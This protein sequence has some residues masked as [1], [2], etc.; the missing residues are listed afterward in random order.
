[1]LS[2]LGENTKTLAMQVLPE[3]GRLKFWLIRRNI[4]SYPWS[5]IV[6]F[7]RN[8]LCSLLSEL[9]NYIFSSEKEFWRWWNHPRRFAEDDVCPSVRQ[10]L[11]SFSCP[12]KE[13][14]LLIS[15][16]PGF[17]TTL[18]DEGCPCFSVLLWQ[19]HN[20]SFWTRQQLRR[21]HTLREVR[22]NVFL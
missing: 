18:G 1:M 21:S 6:C 3:E 7:P 22:K 15:W 4:S 5:V 17:E 20:W 14:K 9:Q 16:F 19:V 13:Q 11:M 8:I 10:C 12:S 2:F